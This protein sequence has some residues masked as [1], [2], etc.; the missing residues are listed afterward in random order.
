MRT[1]KIVVASVLAAAG[2]LVFGLTKVTPIVS[3]RD[4]AVFFLLLLG[5]SFV[6]FGWTERKRKGW[7]VRAALLSLIAAGV[8]AGCLGVSTLLARR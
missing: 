8:A 1:V 4:V 7:P 6:G 5:S 2:T 3:F